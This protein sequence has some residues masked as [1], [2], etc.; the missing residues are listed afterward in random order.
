MTHTPAKQKSTGGEAEADALPEHGSEELEF[1]ST[2]MQ[3]D[4]LAHLLLTAWVMV[5]ESER[6]W[7]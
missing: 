1:S 5:L 7:A 4:R 2:E 6:E 3:N